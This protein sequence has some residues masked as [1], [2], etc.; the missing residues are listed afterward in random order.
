MKSL[1]FVNWC[2]WE[3]SKSAKIWLS[4]S[5]FYVKNHLNLSDIFFSLKNTNIV[6][7]FLLL[8]FLIISIFK[9]L[10]FLKWYSIFHSSPLLQFSKFNNFIWLQLIFSHFV[11]LLEN[12]TTGIAMICIGPR[13]ATESRKLPFDW[14]P[15]CSNNPQVLC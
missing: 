7:H 13:Y 8:A 4:K 2:N 10:Y 3:V 6:A 1:N 15:F 11:S 14:V 12:S 9:S 5:I